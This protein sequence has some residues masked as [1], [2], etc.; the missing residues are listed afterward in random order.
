MTVDVLSVGHYFVELPR[1]EA[2]GTLQ[3][4]MLGA[5]EDGGEYSGAQW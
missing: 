4:N 5:C 3:R 2:T 1:G